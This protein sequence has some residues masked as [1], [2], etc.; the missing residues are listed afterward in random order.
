MPLRDEY[1]GGLE[2]VG[3][4]EAEGGVY[5]EA[6]DREA[7][8]EIYQEEKAFQE[9][10]EAVRDSY[11]SW[12]EECQTRT[13]GWR[14]M[15]ADG[16]VEEE[17]TYWAAVEAVREEAFDPGPDVVNRYCEQYPVASWDGFFLS[18]LINESSHDAFTLPDMDGVSY[19]GYRNEKDVT[20]E[21][22]VE[23]AAG[24]RM[25]E[26]TFTVLGDAGESVGTRMDGGVIELHG[27]GDIAVEDDSRIENVGG[28]RRCT[29]PS[30]EPEGVVERVLDVLE[31]L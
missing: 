26:G 16:D 7:A 12:T 5:D 23:N 27:E 28:V 29:V 9:K 6:V 17:E 15:G 31:G 24:I 4:V 30:A 1:P 21:G 8:E 10:V 20:V 13:R 2:P 14:N 18:A 19:L 25:Q 11:E 22:D 3:P